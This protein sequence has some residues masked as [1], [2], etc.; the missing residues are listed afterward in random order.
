MNIYLLLNIRKSSYVDRKII[1]KIKKFY[2]FIQKN[3]KSNV[4]YFF[5]NK[6]KKSI[7][8]QSKFEKIKLE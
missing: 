4:A 3:C 2:R 8:K 6:I 7:V 5:K 1:N